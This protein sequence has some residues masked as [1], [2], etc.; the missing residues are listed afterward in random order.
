MK[1]VVGE[2]LKN[3]DF[4]LDIATLSGYNCQF[5]TLVKNV[6][7]K[8][9]YSVTGLISIGYSPFL[10]NKILKIGTGGAIEHVTS[11]WW[12]SNIS[13][14]TDSAGYLYITQTGWESMKFRVSSL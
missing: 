14:R 1:V 12:N 8:L 11:P 3:E 6:E 4:A 7:Q 13:F 9:P 2:L 10:Y 5:I